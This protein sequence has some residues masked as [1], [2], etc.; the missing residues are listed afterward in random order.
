M[1]RATALIIGLLIGLSIS[2]VKASSTAS[3]TRADLFEAAALCGVL[4][5]SGH[6]PFGVMGLTAPFQGPSSFTNLA[7]KYARMAQ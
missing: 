7:K 6:D 5:N 1:N 4:A 2:P 3:I